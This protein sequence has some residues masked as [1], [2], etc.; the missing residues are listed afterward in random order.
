MFRN[1]DTTPN[2]D[3]GARPESAFRRLA[4]LDTP[5]LNPLYCHSQ[6]NY[7]HISRS[8]IRLLATSQLFP[9]SERKFSSTHSHA[10]LE[11][12]EDGILVGKVVKVDLLRMHFPL[13]HDFKRDMIR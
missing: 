4:P 7:T 1:A 11:E 6:V 8:V 9:A 10:R 5:S 3:I 2:D 13:L 12:N